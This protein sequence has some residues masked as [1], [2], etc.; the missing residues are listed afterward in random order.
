[1][2][3]LI[4]LYLINVAIG[5]ALALIFVAILL[6]ADVVHLRHLVLETSM[7]WLAGLILVF[8]NGVVFSGVQFGIAVMLMAEDKGGH[9]GGKRQRVTPPLSIPAIV[10]A[11]ANPPQ[12]IG[13][14]DF[15]LDVMVPVAIVAPWNWH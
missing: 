1:M 15:Q 3:K 10:K 7:G 4:R 14:I 11:A 12:A 9:T 6:W 2:P 5:F 13:Q 8:G